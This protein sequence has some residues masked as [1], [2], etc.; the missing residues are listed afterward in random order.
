ME[1][2]P[3]MGRF[4]FVQNLKFLDVKSR[5]Y[6]SFKE[7]LKSKLCILFYSKINNFL[8]YFLTKN[9]VVTKFLVIFVMNKNT[10][11]KK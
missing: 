9:L 1:S 5:L 6:L 4:F 10:I 3:E 8:Q 2:F 11:M 7:S